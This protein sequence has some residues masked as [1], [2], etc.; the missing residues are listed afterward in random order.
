MQDHLYDRALA[1]REEH[2]RRIDDLEQFNAFFTPQNAAKPE[3]HGGFALCHLADEQAADAALKDLK[4][5]VRCLPIDG[6]EEPGRCI[7]TG[8]PS[9]KRAVFAKAY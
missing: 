6:E 8:R 9:T 3:I 1:L 4:V 2:T 7:F 5:T